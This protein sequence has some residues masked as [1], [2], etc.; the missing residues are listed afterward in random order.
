MQALLAEFVGVALFQLL[1]GSIAQGPLQIA[2]TFGAISEWSTHTQGIA[3]WVE[4]GSPPIIHPTR[5]PTGPAGSPGQLP[6]G[7]LHQP[8]TQGPQPAQPACAAV[9]SY[10]W[11][12]IVG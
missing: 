8:V 10:E 5:L 4:K 11:E 6:A 7:V 9:R 12:G 3:T 2:F 1:A